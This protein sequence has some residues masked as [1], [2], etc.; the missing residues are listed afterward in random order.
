MSVPSDEVIQFL[1]GARSLQS[2]ISNDE[3]ILN[4][5]TSTKTPNLLGFKSDPTPDV[6]LRFFG[7]YMRSCVTSKTA[8]IGVKANIMIGRD[9][10]NNQMGCNHD[11]EDEGEDKESSQRARL[12]KPEIICNVVDILDNTLAEGRL[13]YRCKKSDRKVLLVNR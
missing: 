1:K 11:E 12:C 13:G 6:D 2:R 8:S 9:S 7:Q 10:V 5:N 4:S 3:I